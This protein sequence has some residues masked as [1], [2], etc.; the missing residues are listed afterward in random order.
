LL[1]L[2]P[3]SG[4][5]VHLREGDVARLLKTNNGSHEGPPPRALLA[6]PLVSRSGR[7]LGVL[8]VSDPADDAFTDGDEAVVVQLG[9]SV[10]VAL[11]NWVWAEER[12]A[13]RLKDEFLA[14]LSHEL[15]TPLQAM[16]GWTRV[17]LTAP[18][19]TARVV[20]AGEVI[21]RN[22]LAQA[23][24][25]EDLLDLSRITRGKMTLALQAT[26]LYDVV[27]GAIET[28]RPAADAKGVELVLRASSEGKDIHG[29]PDRLRQVVLNLLSNAIKFTP[30]G[31]R[32]EVA[33][34]RL[35]AE[36]LLEVRDAGEGIE[37]SF[38]PLVFDRFRQAD[39]SSR[40][41]HGGLGIGLAVVRHIVE[42]HGGTV[43]AQSQ[44]KGHGATF[45]ARLPAM[46]PVA[47]TAPSEPARAEVAADL[48]GITLLLVEDD[49]DTREVVKEIL[50]DAGALVVTA[51]TARSAL[52]VLDR[53]LPDVLV[54]DLGLP[55]QDGFELMTSVRQSSAE[56]LRAI[57]AIALS[58]YTADRD[59]ARA[60]EVGYQRHLGKPVD[61]ETLVR[62]I[63]DLLPAARSTSAAARAAA[64][65][66]KLLH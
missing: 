37:P 28:Q 15:R 48:N 46:A 22:L 20:K 41:Q 16:L 40:R 52:E 5:V 27:V 19:E 55:G 44:G 42:L 29:D 21:E 38:L 59:A 51:S 14:T 43:T 58:A 10:S 54:S 65:T 57:P 9:Q 3:R 33:L 50:E 2:A 1:S 62:T 7:E 18:G 49:D 11:E 12:E 61:P 30:G 36:I 25:M 53:A 39:G 56:A 31:A 8:A 6:A 24:M 32:V 23:R 17:L 47:E 60:Q 45:V 66:D 13:S 34:E 4:S 63:R 64:R 35:G 26:S